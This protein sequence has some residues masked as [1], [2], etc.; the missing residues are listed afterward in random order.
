[1]LTIIPLIVIII[2]LGAILV[3]ASRH[4]KKAA[5]LDV[6]QLP[7]ERE[8]VLKS[9]LL[10]HRLLRKF[11]A[12]FRN[13]TNIVRPGVDIFSKWFGE[14][15]LRVKKLERS[16]RFRGGLPDSSKKANTKVEELISE[17]E[18]L[19]EKGNFGQAETKYLSA[20]K[21]NP[22][23]AAAYQGLG[24]NYIK[25]QELEQAGETF[26]YMVKEWPQEDAAFAALAQVEEKQ[27]NY[28]EAKGHFL[29]ALSI[30]NEVV[31]Y[32]MDLSELYLRLQDTEKALSSLQKAQALEPNNPKVLD[33]LFMVS[34]LLKNKKLSEEV[35]EKIKKVN[36]DHGRIR[37][38]QKKI[39]E[40]K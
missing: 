21:V 2:S 13:I 18:V 36:P 20:I 23:A 15:F 37:E 1:M 4:L 26:S 16:Y 8:A 33:Q 32:H 31:S 6:G 22:D 29:H 35:L 27:G 38:F 28:E 19:A 30:N 25:M 10:E 24:E 11:D 40:L 12:L 34:T 7:E 9:S 14:G 5:A 39:K 17:A 3:I